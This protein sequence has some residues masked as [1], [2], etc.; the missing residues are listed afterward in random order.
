MEQVE[1][2]ATSHF[3]D[4]ALGSVTRKARRFV[5]PVTADRLEA[6]GVVKIVDPTVA[7]V[8]TPQQ[9]APLV[10]GGDESPASSQAA[11]ASPSQTAEKRPAMDGARLPSM[12]LGNSHHTQM[13][14]MPA[15][16]DGGTT[17]TPRSKLSLSVN[18][19]R[20]TKAQRGDTE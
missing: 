18:S 5:D 20:K 16:A 6:L 3:T 9:T 13:S 11:Q 15:T 17:T 12:T 14:S 7:T 4:F 19:G 8:A 2:V 1:I 10:A